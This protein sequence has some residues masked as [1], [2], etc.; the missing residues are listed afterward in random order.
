MIFNKFI[1]N[2]GT[3]SAF[4]PEKFNPKENKAINPD[5]ISKNENMTD[6]KFKEGKIKKGIIQRIKSP[7][8]NKFKSCFVL[9]ILSMKFW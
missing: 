2:S 1:S 7:I 8:I 4:G 6:S 5:K 9:D 3:E